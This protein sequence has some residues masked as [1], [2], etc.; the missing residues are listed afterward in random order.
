MPRDDMGSHTEADAGAWDR[1]HAD[2]EPPRWDGEDWRG[3]EDDLPPARPHPEDCACPLCG[4]VA[5]ARAL[6]DGA[7]AEGVARLR[8][9]LA[10]RRAAL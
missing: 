3:L 8:A 2:D 5:L 4:A 7:D 10:S 6:R 9:K 1:A